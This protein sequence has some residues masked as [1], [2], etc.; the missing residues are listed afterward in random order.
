MAMSYHYEV[1]FGC[2]LREDTPETVLDTLRWHMGLLK[3]RP[4]FLE[5]DEYYEQPLAPDPDSPL[6]GGD[7]AELRL[8][9]RGWGLLSRSYWLDDDIGWVLDLVELIAPYAATRGYGGF[10]REVGEVVP[11]AFAFADGGF[12]LTRQWGK[13]PLWKS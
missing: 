13:A 6:A 5:R 12:G 1:V 10:F 3:D 9:D 4:G 2:F 11:T 8:Q 7:V